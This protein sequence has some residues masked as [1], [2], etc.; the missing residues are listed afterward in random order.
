MPRARLTPLVPVVVFALALSL[1]AC[2]AAATPGWTYEPPPS[3]TP[4]PS[5]SAG[6]SASAAPSGSAIASASAS[7]GASQPTGQTIEL[8]A[9]NIAYD[10]S[11]LTAPADAPFTI[12]FT[13]ND[14]GVPHN[15]AIKDQ[16]GMDV[17]KGEIF[18]GVDS[19]LYQVPALKAGTYTF[20]CQVHPNMTGTLTVQ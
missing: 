15:V 17:F 3:V 13:N 19:K 5:A 1:A 7:A 10:Q 14:A 20:Y 4:A 11:T 18:N 16:M 2:T 8:S 12:H 6:A 9:Q